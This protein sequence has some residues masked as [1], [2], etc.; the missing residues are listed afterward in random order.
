MQGI[1]H[2]KDRGLNVARGPKF[3]ATYNMIFPITIR[4]KE[5]GNYIYSGVHRLG[6]GFLVVCVLSGLTAVISLGTQ[7]YRRSVIVRYILVALQLQRNVVSNCRGG[8]YVRGLMQKSSFYKIV[9]LLARISSIFLVSRTVTNLVN[10]LISSTAM[11]LFLWVF[12]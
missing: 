4:I 10:S 7:M 8:T 3:E 2:P 5:E 6:F 1:I 9:L 12:L 11:R